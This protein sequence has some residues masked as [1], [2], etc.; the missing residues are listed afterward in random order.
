MDAL[1]LKDRQKAL[2]LKEV[3]HRIKNS[4]QIVSSLLQMQAKTAGAA[5]SQ[6]HAAAARV[7]A[8]VRRCAAICAH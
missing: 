1:E 2:L 8:I 3:D 4:L 5:A 6:F 7:T